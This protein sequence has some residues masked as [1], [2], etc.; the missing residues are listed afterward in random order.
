MPIPSVTDSSAVPPKKLINVM[1]MV[2]F[3]WIRAIAFLFL[4]SFFL[5][6]R[7][8]TF[9]SVNVEWI[10]HWGV[11]QGFRNALINAF[12]MTDTNGVKFEFNLQHTMIAAILLSCMYL[13]FTRT[14]FDIL[15]EGK[16]RA[17]RKAD[18][19]KKKKE[20]RKANYVSDSLTF[21]QKG[22]ISSSTKAEKEK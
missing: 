1:H 5:K 14:T 18:D 19:E 15:R 12:P 20:R 11:L 22:N 3:G 7:H 2:K 6:K 4:S 21:H 10:Q 13:R 17:E 8:S 16:T 9:E